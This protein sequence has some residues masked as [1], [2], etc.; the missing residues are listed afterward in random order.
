MDQQQR[1][2]DH[3]VLAQGLD[4][5]YETLQK[6]CENIEVYLDF[7]DKHLALV[8]KVL[9][10]SISEQLATSIQPLEDA[11]NALKSIQRMQQ[12]LE[13][14]QQKSRDLQ[15]SLDASESTLQGLEKEL[16]S[17]HSDHQGCTA[18]IATLKEKNTSFEQRYE[19][20]LSD[21]AESS[22]RLN[23]E[24]ARVNFSEDQLKAS[25]EELVTIKDMYTKD[26]QN[27]LTLIQELEAS[28]R[29]QNRLLRKIADLGELHRQSQS[30][31]KRKLEDIQRKEP[32]SSA[33]RTT[34]LARNS[35]HVTQIEQLSDELEDSK[36]SIASL[37]AKA[38]GHE[39]TRGRLKQVQEELE[40]LRR[41]NPQISQVKADKEISRLKQEH[42]KELESQ[43]ER[44]TEELR[45]Q[46]Q[47]H[48]D[49]FQRHLDAKN[50]IVASME[51]HQLALEKQV[52]MLEKQHAAEMSSLKHKYQNKLTIASDET[53]HRS[54]MGF[55]TS[56]TNPVSEPNSESALRYSN[57]MVPRGDDLAVVD[58]SRANTSL[59]SPEFD[60]P[61]VMKRKFNDAGTSSELHTS[62][63]AR[64]NPY[65]EIEANASGTRRATRPG[66][67]LSSSMQ[68]TPSI[69]RISARA[70]TTLALSRNAEVLEAA[71]VLAEQ[72]RTMVFLAW[73]ATPDDEAVV[74]NSL[75]SL[76][77]GGRSLETIMKCIDK[78]CIGNL[79]QKDPFP[80]VCFIA[81][82]K[83]ETSG[84]GGPRITQNSCAYCRKLRTTCFWAKHA[85]G[86][87]TGFGP[88]IAGKIS[89]ENNGR[90]YDPS[91]EPRLVDIGGQKVRWILKKRKSAQNDD[92]DPGWV[93]GN[94]TL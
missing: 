62:K 32:R 40:A 42:K 78:Y 69:S 33:E 23:D 2:E 22:K 79:N 10:K 44:H 35:S 11:S 17:V 80:P 87:A 6:T 25:Q 1:V 30:D 47:R 54:S 85:P 71:Q 20:A 8:C 27:V 51:K 94:T 75:T 9:F 12:M 91:A 93:V 46:S 61:S 74:M 81:R 92:S 55:Q 31:L 26:A 14:G 13:E 53:D 73:E 90:T 83:G 84:N 58:R 52:A 16:S 24:I 56:S 45:S 66:N 82:I 68:G 39:A 41:S 65:V 72:L 15:N 70:S 48:A 34:L 88:R 86:V 18:Q 29:E 37:Q 43:S 36:H 4:K 59:G 3:L 5:L 7:D 89:S 63:S 76:F 38:Q 21:L 60:R 28:E 67:S 77:T 64:V 57:A 19:H 50:E 49:E